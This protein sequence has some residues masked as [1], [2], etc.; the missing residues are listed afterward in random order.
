MKQ[1]LLVHKSPSTVCTVT[2][3]LKGGGYDVTC[4]ENGKA[5]LQN[6]MGL[7]YDVLITGLSIPIMNGLEL[8][9]NIR[10]R[11]NCVPVIIL[12]GTASVETAVEAMRI[13]A[14]DFVVEKTENLGK[15]LLFVIERAI[16]LKRAERRLQI[17][18]SNLPICMHCKKIRYER[19]NNKDAWVSI[20]KYFNQKMSGVNFSHGICP[21]CIKKYYPESHLN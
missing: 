3:F 15:T 11:D 9:K 5:A 14:D 6:V 8:I 12:S 21:E 16:Q 13:G 4:V 1:L 19:E 10:L 20:E 18:E 7:K 2:S 17:Y